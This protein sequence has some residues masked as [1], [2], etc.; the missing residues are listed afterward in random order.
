MGCVVPSG[1]HRIRLHFEPESFR[2]GARIS[3]LA[4]AVLLAWS[5]VTLDRWR[6]RARGV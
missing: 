3:G 6:A 1:L 5:I 4:L 2:W